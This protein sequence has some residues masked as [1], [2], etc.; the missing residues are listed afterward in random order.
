MVSWENWVKIDFYEKNKIF[1]F[2]PTALLLLLWSWICLYTASFGNNLFHLVSQANFQCYVLILALQNL[3]A[4]WFRK[5][6]KVKIIKTVTT[7]ILS[8]VANSLFDWAFTMSINLSS[9]D[10]HQSRTNIEDR[11][12][13][14]HTDRPKSFQLEAFRIQKLLHF[15]LGV[16]L[17]GHPGRFL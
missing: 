12:N 14:R 7:K 9:H 6:N 13:R 10:Q 1:G 2:R 16:F 17:E 11:R 15:W 5:R 8:I 3:G 4:R